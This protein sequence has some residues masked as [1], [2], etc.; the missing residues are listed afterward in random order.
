MAKRKGSVET[1]QTMRLLLGA[2][3]DVNELRKK[4]GLPVVRWP[5]Y[6]TELD[7]KLHNNFGHCPKCVSGDIDA[8][9]YDGDKELAVEVKC[10]SCGHEWTEFYQFVGA[11]EA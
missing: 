2:Q 3:I 1:D 9:D 8:S 6:N 11:T 10:G 7:K 4:L 5:D